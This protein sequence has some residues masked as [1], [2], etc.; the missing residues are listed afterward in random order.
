MHSLNQIKSANEAA[1][2]S[3]RTAFLAK[4]FA[5]GKSYYFLT[6]DI[7][8]EIHSFDS[9]ASM[10]AHML[11]TVNTSQLSAYTVRYGAN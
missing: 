6:D 11:A 7:D 9:A 8:S 5:A 10:R 1:H 2:T 3:A 4:L